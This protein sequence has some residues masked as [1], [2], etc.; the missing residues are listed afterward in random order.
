MPSYICAG[1]ALVQVPKILDSIVMVFSASKQG[2]MANPVTHELGYIWC[3]VAAPEIGI[4]NAVEG[5]LSYNRHGRYRC[6]LG[7][8]FSLSLP[9]YFKRSRTGNFSFASRPCSPSIFSEQQNSFHLAWLRCQRFRLIR[10]LFEGRYTAKPPGG[11]RSP[12][13]R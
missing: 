11:S 12:S 13:F 5:F 8:S 10:R 9:P 2:Q 3:V 6:A 4:D 1:I 7:M